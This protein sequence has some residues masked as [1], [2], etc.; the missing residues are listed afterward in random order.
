MPPDASAKPA[1][2]NRRRTVAYAIGAVA[3]VLVAATAMAIGGQWADVGPWANK[4]SAGHGMG[5]MNHTS[6]NT[7]CDGQG[8][9]ETGGHASRGNRTREGNTSCGGNWTHGG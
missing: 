4:A 3:L 6:G 1:N 8:M 2:A 9:H 7:T 5:A